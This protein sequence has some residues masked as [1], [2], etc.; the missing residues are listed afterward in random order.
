MNW[1][2]KKFTLI[3]LLVVIAIIAIL[4][5]M[6]LPALNKAREKAKASKCMSNI[7]NLA[8]L[9]HVYLDDSNGIYPAL[10]YTEDA[11]LIQKT[12]FGAMVEGKYILP[13]DGNGFNNPILFCPGNTYKVTRY[14]TYSVVATDHTSDDRIYRNTKTLK[15]PSEKMIM[16]DGSNKNPGSDKPTMFLY[17]LTANSGIPFLRHGN[18][19]P[20]SFLDGHAS[21]LLRNDFAGQKYFWFG[22][23]TATYKFETVKLSNLAVVTP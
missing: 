8:L 5:A 3:E 2:S 14:V 23:S 17:Y 18:S 19:A 11:T 16:G 6:L 9:L 20:Y 10:A 21:F 4:A 13:V 12:L 22:H 15:N 1:R 7:K